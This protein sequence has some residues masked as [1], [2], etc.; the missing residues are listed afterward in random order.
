MK[1]IIIMII[2]LLILGIIIYFAFF[3][4][5]NI[6]DNSMADDNLDIEKGDENMSEIS[7][8]ITININGVDFTVTLEDNETARE[9]VNRLPLNIE[10]NELNGNE[11]YYYFDESFPSNSSRIER[12]EKGD[13]MLYGSDCLV[14]FYESFNTSYSY[15]R[16]G[17][18]DNPSLLDD[19]IGK[20]SVRVTITE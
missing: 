12:I 16:I 11:K 5:V 2:C 9:L 17:K 1:K 20:D 8:K 7:N 13:I 6:E 18:L 15:T 4:N 14:L 10:M 3:R 19:V